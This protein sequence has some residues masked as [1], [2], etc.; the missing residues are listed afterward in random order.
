MKAQNSDRTERKGIGIAM[1]AFESIDFAFREQFE[2]DYGIDAHVELITDEEPT[3]RLLSLQL[4]SGTSYLSKT[5]TEGYVFRTDKEH[6]DYWLNHSL[7]VLI[8]L[9]DI[10]KKCI[11][12]Q[13]VNSET[14]V[15]TG[16]GFKVL[17]PFNQL[18]DSSSK[19]QL[20]DLLTLVVPEEKY[21]FFK[22]NDTSHNAAKRYSFEIVLNGTA[23]KAEI[24]AI[25]RQV[26]N[27]GQKR[28]YQRNYLVEGRWGDSDA[29]VVWTFV[30]PSAEDHSR[31]NYICRS[32][33]INETLDEQFRPMGFDGENIGDQIIVD[34]SKNYEFMAKYVATNT[35]TKEAYFSEVLPRIDELKKILKLF[36]KTLIALSSREINE[37]EFLHLTNV[38][39][40]RLDEIYFELGDLSFAPFEC[41]EI[42]QQLQSFVALLHN[43]WLYYSDYAHD[44][45][46]EKTRLEQSLR[47][48]SYAH[49]TLQYLE[50]E[51]KKVR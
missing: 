36:E 42:D 46:D 31:H 33:W 25:V 21:T 9:C 5:T 41:K 47:Q 20:Q 48:R 3:G 24:A 45:W 4:K 23:S 44:K 51:L 28:R 12:W 40:K 2:S 32:I 37:T 17:V 1:T 39:R 7:P 15:S 16:K 14:A 22:T 13:I 8:C 30:Y 49:E 27:Q 34:W 26:T 10:D 19:K 11:Y 50:Y 38:E 18:I 35:L 6:V 29:H 43:I